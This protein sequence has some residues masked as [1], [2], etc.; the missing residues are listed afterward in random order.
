MELTYM[1]F[2]TKIRIA[3]YFFFRKSKSKKQKK[4]KTKMQ[5]RGQTKELNKKKNRT[6]RNRANPACV[7]LACCLLV[8]GC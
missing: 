5:T 3:S 4:E 1:L 8:A 6:P 2:V 7:L